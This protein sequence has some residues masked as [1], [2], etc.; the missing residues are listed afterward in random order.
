MRFTNVVNWFVQTARAINFSALAIF[1]G[2]FKNAKLSVNDI[3]D[4]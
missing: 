2:G 3:R 4:E 1:F